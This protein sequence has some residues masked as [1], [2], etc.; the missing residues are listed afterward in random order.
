MVRQPDGTLAE[1][2]WTDALSVAARGLLAA[3]E[4]GIG[5]LAGGRLTVEDA[6]AYAK[7]A[8]V[9]AGTNDVD[10]RARPHSGEELEFLAAHV[11]GQGPEIL[12]YARL[13]AAST[14]LCV[15][16]E[17]EEEAPIVFLRL[18]KAVRKRGQHVYHLGQWTTPAVERTSPFTGS[19]APAAKDNLIPAVPG[20]E[21]AVLGDLPEAVLSGLARG[22]V[23]LVGERAA[24]VPG[25]YSA[26]SALA[27]RTG[28]VVGWVPRRAGE[29]GA[30]DAGAAPTL[31][32]GG[33]PVA[34]AAA[35]AEVEA[36]WGLADGAL[37]TTPGRD[38]DAIL[39]AAG[40]GELAALVVGGLDP[41]D[42]ADP[43]AALAGLREVGFLVSLE[44]LRSPVT[45]LA[46]VVL[47]VAPDV[48]RSGTYH[49]WEGRRPVVRAR[50]R[51]R[52]ASCPT[53]GCSTRWPSR[54]TSTCSP[55]PRR[56]R[57]AS[58]AGSG[59]AP[60][61][62]PRRRASPRG[63]PR[64]PGFGQA[65]LATWRQLIDESSL[66]VDEPHLAG[67]ARPALVRVNAA[68]A[69]PA[70]AHRGRARHG[71]HRARRDHTAGGA[72]R[73]A[74]RRGV[75]AGQ[76]RRIPGPRRARRRPRRPGGGDG[77][78][79]ILGQ[80]QPDGGLT[81]T[82]QLLAD[83]PLWLI[84]IK[85]VGLFA[86][87]VVLTLFMINWERKVVGRMQ[88]RPGPNRVGPNGWLQSLADG[89]K[90]AFK[91]DIMPVMAD[92]RV[93]FIAPVISAIPAFVAFSVIP[94][95]G[96]VTIFGEPT[97]LQLVDLPVG[98]LVVLA[99]S[100][101][102]VY[103][104]VL[105]GWSSGSPYP[106]LA[107]AAL[108]RAGDLL[109]DRARP[110]GGRDQDRLACGPVP[111]RARHRAQGL[112]LLRVAPGQPRGDDPRHVREHPPAQ[113]TGPR[114]PRAVSP[115]TSP[116]DGERPPST[117][118][119]S[120][121]AAA[122]TPLVI[123]A[124]KEYGSGSSRDWAAK[125]TALLGVRAVIAESYE[126]IHRSNLIG[127]GVL[128]L[129]FPEGHNGR[130]AGPDR[131]GDLRHHR[132]RC[133]EL[134]HDA[135]HRARQAGRHRVRRRACASTPPARRTTTATAASCS[136]CC[137]SCWALRSRANSS[138]RRGEHRGRCPVPPHHA[139]DR[140]A[141]QGARPAHPRRVRSVQP[142]RV[143]RRRT[144][145]EDQTTHRG[146]RRAHHPMP[147][148][149]PRPHPARAPRRRHRRGDHGSDLG[150]RRNARRRRLRPL[151]P[152][153]RGTR[154]VAHLTKE[155][156]VCQQLDTRVW[157][158]TRIDPNAQQAVFAM[159][160]YVHDS[161]LDP[162]LYELVKIRASQLNGC[163]FCL[164]MHNRDAR[165]GG[166]DQRRLDVLSAWREAPALFTDPRAGGA[167]RSPKR[168]PASATRG[169]PDPVWD[170]VAAHFDEAGIVQLLMAIATINV[171]NRLAVATH[172]QLPDLTNTLE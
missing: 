137:G 96:E 140:Q 13:E 35:R 93:Y 5:V 71:A 30:L 148:L 37:P 113:P 89:L 3:R 14:V 50:A 79:S 48:Q 62:R 128:P 120:N 26:V 167:R 99:C 158:C 57:R 73:S 23:I 154:Q 106:L 165:A 20:A 61:P 6:Y 52:A 86:L 65:V 56:L 25:L 150:R 69:R 67:T 162:R 15:A 80:A 109:R 44:M 18:R 164:D 27:T 29:R 81:H 145:R 92:K 172:Q 75:A 121:Y 88:Q 127:M 102:G 77:V 64:T 36:A 124:G 107:R 74:R 94:F 171:W 33:R 170:D 16:L 1:T 141:T 2:S 76:L 54:W 66:A 17:P 84:I 155:T 46:D 10:F 21:A 129:Q 139:G 122:G 59:R 87:G 70:R 119:P 47:P 142:G 91:E 43:A 60:A 90:L 131:R 7:F 147:V 143:R 12:D 83:D 68:T 19:A 28:A 49:N 39:A 58:S 138:I 159:E 31:L 45:E 160:R 161:G 4:G 130:V 152:R 153:P 41:Y 85:V 116:A 126:R 100:A 11:V 146:R 117:R 168:S 55:R 104:I 144:A 134:R 108:G 63:R 101:V 42:L 136:T 132:R 151:H 8:R 51:R 111:D 112:Q 123:L 103:G 135:A 32:P 9:A 118:R 78:I 163:A 166:E 53:A 114:G 34:D 95:G 115:A 72:G 97:V 82:Q 125:G 40:L 24:E 38:T 133:A 98:V 22:G 156:P 157:T 105:G 110:L 169:V 149:H